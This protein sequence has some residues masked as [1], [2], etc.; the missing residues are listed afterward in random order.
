M[1]SDG[2]E[3]GARSRNIPLM[4]PCVPNPRLLHGNILCI[5][6]QFRSLTVPFGGMHFLTSSVLLPP[7]PQPSAPSQTLKLVLLTTLIS[8]THGPFLYSVRMSLCIS[9]YS[10]P[11]AYLI[12]QL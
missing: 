12:G 10:R 11:V 7:A 8:G 1:D 3:R 9:R 2:G 4:V 6:P 5:V